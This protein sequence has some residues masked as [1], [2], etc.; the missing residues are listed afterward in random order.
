MRYS[1]SV[2]EWNINFFI[3]KPARE[4]EKSLESEDSRLFGAARQIRTADLILTKCRG[5]KLLVGDRGISCRR[6]PLPFSRRR[7]LPVLQR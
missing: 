2:Y 6:C 7:I 1:F 4:K 3:E 5:G